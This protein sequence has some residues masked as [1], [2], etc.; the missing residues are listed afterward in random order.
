M[1]GLGLDSNNGHVF[2]LQHQ[3]EPFLVFFNKSSNLIKSLGETG[4]FGPDI[5]GLQSNPK[6]TRDAKT[7]SAHL[8]FNGF[9][10]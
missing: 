9:F 3:N 10:V 2:L 1:V 8:S 4:N 6:N 5:A 7:T